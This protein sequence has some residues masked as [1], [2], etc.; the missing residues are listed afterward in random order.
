MPLT[1]FKDEPT[2][3]IHDEFKKYYVKYNVEDFFVLYDQNKEKFTFYNKN[4]FKSSLRLHLHL[5]PVIHLSFAKA[6]IDIAY[7]ILNVLNLT[8]E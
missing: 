5:R 4:Q 2:D 7:Q 3:E 6:R 8:K 1:S